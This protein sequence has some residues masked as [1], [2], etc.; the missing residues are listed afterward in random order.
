MLKGICLILLKN[1]KQMEETYERYLGWKAG[2]DK[3]ALAPEILKL[4][5]SGS[6]TPKTELLLRGCSDS[7]SPTI[8]HFA[9]EVLKWAV[10]DD[11]KRAGQ[12]PE[13]QKCGCSGGPKTSCSGFG[14][15]RTRRLRLNQAGLAPEVL[16]GAAWL[17]KY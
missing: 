13:I 7:K 5:C 4:G 8:N 12:A 17:Q 1:M 9:P 15:P 6:G 11:L 16:N 10:L 2:V 3:A 14:R